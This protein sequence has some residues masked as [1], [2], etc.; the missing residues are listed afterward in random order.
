MKKYMT[1]IIALATL[2]LLAGCTNGRQTTNTNKE[3]LKIQSFE[4]PTEYES[5]LSEPDVKQIDIDCGPVSEMESQKYDGADQLHVFVEYI[6]KEFGIQI[7]DKWT[8]LIHFYDDERTVGMIKF[9]YWIG[10]IGTD[11]CITYN[12][13][14]GKSDTVFYTHLDESVDEESLLARVQ[15]F[16]ERYEQEKRELKVVQ[17]LFYGLSK[18]GA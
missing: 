16:E 2:F 6:E 12:L 10:N 15:I 13:E 3:I 1:F 11:K 5:N 17:K 14:Q 4:E 7:D 18:G 8:V 9:Q